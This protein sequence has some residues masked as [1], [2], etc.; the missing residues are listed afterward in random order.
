M[1]AVFIIPGKAWFLIKFGY[2][3]RSGW[4]LRFHQL[5]NRK[6]PITPD[7]YTKS[8]EVLSQD[9]LDAA[10]LESILSLSLQLRHVVLAPLLL[11]AAGLVPLAKVVQHQPPR[12]ARLGH[13]GRHFGR[14]VSM[15]HRFFPV[16]VCKRGLVH[17]DVC[18]VAQPQ[19]PFPQDGTAVA[20]DAHFPPGGGVFQHLCWQN[21]AP[22]LQ[23]Y[24]L[25]GFEPPIKGPWFQTWG[26][27]L[28]N[29]IKFFIIF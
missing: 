12:T 17:Q 4:N 7:G 10:V 27:D 1:L 20:Q 5:S 2:K 26:T 18:S 24:R 28:K 3:Q 15:F 29:R 13:R 14:A 19:G 16:L 8:Q 11:C 23:G 21:Q 25:P 22:A 9:H 6:W